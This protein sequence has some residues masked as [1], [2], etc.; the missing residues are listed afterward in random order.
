[1][2]NEAHLEMDRLERARCSSQGR[3]LQAGGGSSSADAAVWTP[4]I[5]IRKEPRQRVEPLAVGVVRALVGPLGLQYLVERLRLVVTA[6][7]LTY[8]PPQ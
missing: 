5:V 2:G 8:K 6:R 4:V 7:P 3:C 1:M